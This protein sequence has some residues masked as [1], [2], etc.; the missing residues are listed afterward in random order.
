MGSAKDVTP[1]AEWVV[2]DGIQRNPGQRGPGIFSPAPGNPGTHQRG[3]AEAS[4]SGDQG[5]FAFK[6]L[7]QPLQQPLAWHEV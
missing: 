3:L 1:E 5:Q 6:T 2:V 4:G 7:I